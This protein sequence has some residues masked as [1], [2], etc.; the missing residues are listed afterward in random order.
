MYSCVNTY[1]NTIL[2]PKLVRVHQLLY[3]IFVYASTCTCTRTCTQRYILEHA[4]IHEHVP[5]GHIYVYT[6]I[7]ISIPVAAPIAVSISIPTSISIYLY[8][9]TYVHSCMSLCL[10]TQTSPRK[11]PPT[12]AQGSRYSDAL[13]ALRGSSEPKRPGIPPCNGIFQDGFWEGWQNVLGSWV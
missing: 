7:H 11:R 6:Y 13:P 5:M 9:H 10:C 3:V 2:V 8:I 4:N 1:M 12:T